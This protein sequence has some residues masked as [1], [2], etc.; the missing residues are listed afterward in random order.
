M[1]RFLGLFPFALSNP[2]P[3]TPTAVPSTVEII[4]TTVIT[5]PRRFPNFKVLV[6]FAKVIKTGPSTF[7]IISTVR[8]KGRTD[9]LLLV[10]LGQCLSTVVCPKDGRILIQEGTKC[11]FICIT[12]IWKQSA[13][14]KGDTSL[15]R[16]RFSAFCNTFAS[17]K[18]FYIIFLAGLLPMQICSSR[19][20]LCT[21]QYSESNRVPNLM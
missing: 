5:V 4:F 11:S 15:L 12:Y 2:H 8:I 3:E 7:G 6:P 16:F 21:I 13:I 20:R 17:K 14:T 10:P 19:A 18:R 9:A 1:G